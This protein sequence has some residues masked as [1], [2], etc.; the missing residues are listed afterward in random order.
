MVDNNPS[1]TNDQGVDFDA[2]SA[3]YAA[4]IAELPNIYEKNL[5]GND[6]QAAMQAMSF[7]APARISSF[8]VINVDNTTA[9]IAYNSSENRAYVSFDPTNGLGDRVDN[10]QRGRKAHDLGGHV[11]RGMFNDIVENQSSNENF[12]GDNMTEVIGMVLHDYAAQS[13]NGQLSVDFVGF[14]SG[15]AK[16]AMAAGQMISEGFFEENPNIQLDNVY[17]FGPPAYA[18][19]EFTAAL[20]TKAAELGADVWMVQVHGDE[21]PAVL[22]ENGPGMFTRFDYQQ[23]GEHIY[24]IPSSSEGPARI[25]VNPTPEQRE[26]LNA[27]PNVPRGEHTLDSYKNTM[28]NLAVQE[29]N[30]PEEALTRDLNSDRVI[31]PLSQ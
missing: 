7:A 28:T 14:S 24:A 8:N 13:E 5:S 17:T 29:R 2:Q 10:L 23:A 19:E 1:E 6:R 25:L 15:G 30:A 18:D 12:P 21:M 11:H 16:G 4:R 20:E 31:A 3:A 9:V 26:A 27:D 22:S